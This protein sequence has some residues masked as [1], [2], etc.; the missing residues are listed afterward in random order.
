[1][2]LPNH[3]SLKEWSTVI[4]ALGRGE[5]IL[6][7]RK[8]GIADPTFGVEAE[9]FYL[10][11]TYFHSGSDEA[12]RPVVVTHWAEVVKTWRVRELERLSA[13]EP[14]TIMDRSNLHTRYRF[15]ADQALHV[16]AVR[17]W[18]LPEPV[19]IAL[20]PEYAGCRSWVSIDDEIDVEGSVPALSESE[21][22]RRIEEVASVLELVRSQSSAEH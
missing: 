10:F 16:L 13:L 18:R 14:F 4:D 2:K 11:P 20:K 6:L 5:Q 15:R 9:R 19:T 3:T 8:G 1:M 22:A 7:I 12:P 17:A 21:L